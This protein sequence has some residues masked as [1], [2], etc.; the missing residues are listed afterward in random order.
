[1]L[2]YAKEQGW[3]IKAEGAEVTP[4]AEPRVK[5]P[6]PKPAGLDAAEKPDG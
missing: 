2:G 6:E 1:M 3:L 5:L 4:E